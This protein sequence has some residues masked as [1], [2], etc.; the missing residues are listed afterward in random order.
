M[1]VRLREPVPSKVGSGGGGPASMV[2]ILI[3]RMVLVAF[4]ASLS[5]QSED[6][7]T[8]TCA[9]QLIQTYKELNLRGPE[10]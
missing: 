2:A 6:N 8:T 3:C 5:R 1:C 4:P 10:N 7:L 9:D